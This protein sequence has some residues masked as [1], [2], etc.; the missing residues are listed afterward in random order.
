MIASYKVCNSPPGSEHSDCISGPPSLF[1]DANPF[2]ETPEDT[3]EKTGTPD[4]QSAAQHSDN[5]SSGIHHPLPHLASIAHESIANPS[6][7][8]RTNVEHQQSDRPSFAPDTN[9]PTQIAMSEQVKQSSSGGSQ[10]PDQQSMWS[11]DESGLESGIFNSE[12]DPSVPFDAAWGLVQSTSAG[13]PSSLL[14]GPSMAPLDFTPTRGDLTV[15][16]ALSEGVFALQAD[17]PANYSS[18]SANHE[19]SRELPIHVLRPQNRNDA[20]LVGGGLT[21]GRM[22][23]PSLSLNDQIQDR[24]VIDLDGVEDTPSPISSSLQSRM[25]Q[26]TNDESKESKS[27]PVNNTVHLAS[28]KATVPAV[29]GGKRKRGPHQAEVRTESESSEPDDQEAEQLMPDENLSAYQKW[30]SNLPD[31]HRTAVRNDEV[32]ASL[33]NPSLNGQR[34][35]GSGIEAMSAAELHRK[36]DNEL[37]G[38]INADPTTDATASDARFR[39]AEKEW[40]SYDSAYLKRKKSNLV[41]D[42]ED[43]TFYKRKH[44]FERLQLLHE[45]EVFPFAHGLD[46]VEDGLGLRSAED[47]A[48]DDVDHM[49]PQI[50]ASIRPNLH[51]TASEKQEREKAEKKLETQRK[52]QMTASRKRKL[53]D[54]FMEG[55]SD[56]QT[57]E[58]KKEMNMR[59]RAMRKQDKRAQ[60]EAAATGEDP[61]NGIGL[62][63]DINILHG[64][65]S[66]DVLADA[67]ATAAKSAPQIKVTHTGRRREALQQFVN[68]IPADAQAEVAETAKQI[69]DA[70]ADLG[71][72]FCR[73]DKDTG[74]GWRLKGVD[75]ILRHHQLLAVSL[76]VKQ[77]SGSNNARGGLLADGMGF[78]KTIE[79]L[80]T[81]VHQE[82]IRRRNP[83]AHQG[84]KTTLIVAPAGLLGQWQREIQRWCHKGLF[85]RVQKH[86]GTT[87]FDSPEMI[88]AADIVLTTYTEVCRSMPDLKKKPECIVDS[89]EV[90]AWWKTQWEKR[91]PLHK[92]EYLRVVLDESQAIANHNSRTSTGCR[93]LTAERHWAI[94]GTPVLNGIDSFYSYL[95]FFKLGSEA[96]TYGLFLTKYCNYGSQNAMR[97]LLAFLRGYM[98]R[99]THKDMILG[100]SICDLPANYVETKIIDFNPVERAVYEIVRT[101]FLSQIQL[102]KTNNVLEKKYNNILVMLLR[103]RQM[104][105]HL[106][107]CETT[108]TDLFTLEDID[109]IYRVSRDSGKMH[110]NGTTLLTKNVIKDMDN[111][112]HQLRAAVT[113]AAQRQ[114]GSDAHVELNDGRLEDYNLLPFM[115]LMFAENEEK[116]RQRSGCHRCND[117]PEQAIAVK[118]CAHIYCLEC[119]HS[120]ARDAALNGEERTICLACGEVYEGFT[121]IDSFRQRNANGE[122]EDSDYIDIVDPHGTDDDEQG[123]RKGK[124]RKSGS[125]PKVAKSK[126]KAKSAGKQASKEKAKAEAT[127]KRMSPWIVKGDKML[128][129][130]KL[131]AIGDKIREVFKANEEEKIIIFTQMLGMI[132][133]IGRY[134]EELDRG[135]AS[136]AK[137]YRYLEYSG[138]QTLDARNQALED[139]DASK[140]TRIMVAS[141]RCGGVGLNL[142]AA[143]QVILVDLWWN[144]AVEDQAFCRVFVSLV[145]CS[146]SIFEPIE[147]D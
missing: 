83:A 1:L 35:V 78:G 79:M 65:L 20:V 141:L 7:G 63:S 13:V 10:Y 103:L 135:N 43:M 118:P 4:V 87:K 134:L 142:T 129:S 33:L 14:T 59:S 25:V 125:N 39:L 146:L 58:Q 23:P 71:R 132:D 121:K 76:M 56:F 18:F 136:Q 126:A 147:T 51:E 41:D 100:R 17:I 77:E 138:R 106:F 46:S 75:A 85:P 109:R 12:Q 66:T 24:I 89:K 123:S 92:A 21:S 69:S 114:H 54:A 30:H 38:D 115:K 81:M 22:T 70:V 60:K 98:I 62:D 139:F 52:R 91:G 105:A 82:F 110:R 72:G 99:R 40:R 104:T 97:R 11:F 47:Q 124:K 122:L 113:A 144:Q 27:K 68:G 5:L 31:R 143:S 57:P 32:P 34:S 145:V 108:I 127:V 107:L 37:F 2:D 42:V 130:A 74:E 45:Q 67:N 137:R 15:P 119:F 112:L 84:L 50:P 36:Q 49:F 95:R 133:I 102:F 6:D 9:L 29:S 120:M 73:W 19:E 86:H 48:T 26:R 96:P 94:S 131:A 140:S 53:K 116:I 111:E 88:E 117:F 101:R 93:A 61:E 44:E 55:L 28:V 3:F 16:A 8:P 80:A 64:L 90:M 128:P